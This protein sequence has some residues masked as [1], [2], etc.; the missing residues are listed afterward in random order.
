LAKQADYGIG[1]CLFVVAMFLFLWRARLK[2]RDLAPTETVPDSAGRRPRIRTVCIKCAAFALTLLIALSL[3]SFALRYSRDTT[4]K[5]ASFGA[6]MPKQIGDFALTHTWYEQQG[7]T[8]VEENGAYSAP[9]SDEVILGVWVAPIYYFHSTTWCWLARGLQPDILTT[10]QFLTA[11]GES[12]ALNTGFYSDGITDS[13]VM[14]P[15]VLLRRAR[16]FSMPH[17]T[18]ESESSSWSLGWVNLPGQDS[19]RFR[20]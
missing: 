11:G 4:A 14:T 6:R 10:R 5:P 12:L 18:G 1:S 8:T 3:P 20:S 7:G 13:I 17:R 2:Q 9:G 19:T 16:S 15:H